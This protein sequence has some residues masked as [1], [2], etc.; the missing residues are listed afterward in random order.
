MLSATYVDVP[1]GLVRVV[2]AG[3]DA[4]LGGVTTDDVVPLLL[5]EGPDGT[6]EEAGGDQIEQAGGCDEEELQFR[7]RAAPGKTER[8]HRQPKCL[9]DA[10]GFSLEMVYMLDSLVEDVADD[11]TNNQTDDDRERDRGSGGGEGNPGDED[12]GL[13]TLAENGDEGQDEHEVLLEETLDDAVPVAGVDLGL[14]GSGQLDA[15]LLL[16]LTDTEERDADDGDDARGDQAEGAFVV[17]L[18]SI[19]LVGTDRVEGTDE[20]TTNDHAEQKTKTSTQ[21]DLSV[22]VSKRSTRLERRQ[23][24]KKNKRKGG[25]KKGDKKVQE[26]R[27][28]RTSFL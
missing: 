18:G 26:N 16:H 5:L 21:P 11:G 27:T 22:E 23:Q 19:P 9:L 20:S 13:D 25:E 24:E 6:G 4:D 17:V 12:D 1:D 15:P 10:R 14:H 2:R 7:G 8:V 28:C 3:A